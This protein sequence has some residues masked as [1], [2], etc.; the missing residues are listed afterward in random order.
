MENVVL[1]LA[2]HEAERK[3][4]VETIRGRFPAYPATVYGMGEFSFRALMQELGSF[5]LFA[6]MRVVVI[7]KIELLKKEEAERLAE[8]L[9]KLSHHFFI[10]L[11]GSSFKVKWGS[12]K[13]H[14][15]TQ[16]KPWERSSR[17]KLWLQEEAKQAGKVLPPAVV[18]FLVEEGVQDFGLLQQELIK[19]IC[20]VGERTLIELADAK[21]MMAPSPLATGW[22]LAEAIIW[23]GKSLIHEPPFEIAHIGQI[24]YHLQ[25]GLQMAALLEQGKGPTEMTSI[26]GLKPRMIEKYLVPV[27]KRGPIFFRRGLEALFECELGCKNGICPQILWTRFKGEL[28]R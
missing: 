22:E 9:P 17:L 12:V 21:A 28:L 11:S 10:I 7:E 16:E 26:P 14:D 15:L 8:L 1:V 25:I 27:R 23:E 4:I 13:T 24:R 18:S 19:L 2:A 3:K 20:Y 5:D 6:P